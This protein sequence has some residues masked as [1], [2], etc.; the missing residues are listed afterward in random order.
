M[1]QVKIFKSV[2]TNLDDLE[3][4]INDWIR[5][6]GAKV[7]SIH[8][9]IAPQS[10]VSDTKQLSLQQTTGTSSDVLILVLYEAAEA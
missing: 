3:Q 4:E 10:G 6:S 5:Q 8:G 7:L 9:N 1:Q 2:E